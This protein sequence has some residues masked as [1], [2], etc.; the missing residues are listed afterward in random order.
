MGAGSVASKKNDTIMQLSNVYKA[1]GHLGDTYT[2]EPTEP[3]REVLR[4]YKRDQHGTFVGKSL[5]ISSKDI[6]KTYKVQNY[7]RRTGYYEFINTARPERKRYI[8]DE[9]LCRFLLN[10]Q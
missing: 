8:K 3:G 9:R 4:F 6:G 2:F 1:M 7:N 10:E 5:K